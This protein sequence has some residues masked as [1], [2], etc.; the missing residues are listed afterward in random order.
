MQS[1]SVIES[2]DVVSDGSRRLLESL[3]L[4][5]VD[6]FDFE[7]SEEALHWCVVVT[8]SSVAHALVEYF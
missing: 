1:F 7:A 4:L 8:V 6:F 5:P 2:I 3:V